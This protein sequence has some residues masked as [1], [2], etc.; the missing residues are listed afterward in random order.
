M[1]KEVLISVKALHLEGDELLTA[2]VPE[3]EAIETITAGEYFYKNGKHFIIYDE[4]IQ[5][6]DRITKNTVKFSDEEVVLTRR[7]GINVQMI[8]DLKRRTVSNYETP[9]GNIVI[10]VITDY[11]S[12]SESDN[13]I[14]LTIDYKMDSNFEMI[15]KSSLTIEITPQSDGVKLL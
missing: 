3:S 6:A 8:F 13:K 5:G 1:T 9:L 11:I 7:V 12:V 10:G 4:V 14:T 15:S 2:Q